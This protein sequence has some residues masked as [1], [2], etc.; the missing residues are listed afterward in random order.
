MMDFKELDEMWHNI[1]ERHAAEDEGLAPDQ[2][3]ARDNREF[4]AF[5]EELGLRRPA[6]AG[7]SPE[8]K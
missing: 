4:A 2:I 1:R 6:S 3:V 7:T 8:N 5:C